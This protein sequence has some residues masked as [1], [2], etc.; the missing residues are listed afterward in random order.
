MNNDWDFVTR[1]SYYGKVSNLDSV[2]VSIRRHSDNISASHKVI[3]NE[4]SLSVLLRQKLIE[5]KISTLQL[6][7]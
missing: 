6:K 5:K 2:V 7:R 3:E 4:E 1:L